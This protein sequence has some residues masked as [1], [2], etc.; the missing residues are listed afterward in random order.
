MKGGFISRGNSRCIFTQWAPEG[1]LEQIFFFF[2]VPI[3]CEIENI[4]SGFESFGDR[5]HSSGP[6]S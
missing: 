4:F 6:C 1:R 5:S 3:A 2:L